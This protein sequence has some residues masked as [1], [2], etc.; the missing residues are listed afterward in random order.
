M[1][2]SLVSLAYINMKFEQLSGAIVI[3]NRIHPDLNHC[4]KIKVIF[5]A[6]TLILR[7]KD[8]CGEYTVAGISTGILFVAHLRLVHTSVVIAIVIVVIS[9]VETR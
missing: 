5:A 3:A 4:I 8:C 6:W 9:N 7:A 1:I 2:I